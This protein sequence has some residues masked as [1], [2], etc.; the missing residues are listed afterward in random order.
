MSEL[1]APMRLKVVRTRNA[2]HPAQGTE[3]LGTTLVVG[4][5]G[6]KELESDSYGF[7]MVTGARHSYVIWPQNVD[8]AEP[9]A[10]SPT[11]PERAD[12]TS[13]EEERAAAQSPSSLGKKAV[14]R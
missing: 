8:W 11:E 4:E 3:V 6:I 1:R 14:R 10:S 9:L 2:T 12:L 7:V 13:N 5:R